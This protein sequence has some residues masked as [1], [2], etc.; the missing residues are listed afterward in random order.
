MSKQAKAELKQEVLNAID[1][2]V[3]AVGAGTT[4]KSDLKPALF[5]TIVPFNTNGVE[6]IVRKML[7][8]MSNFI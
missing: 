6:P 8:G 2:I 7:E 5:A 1:G 4:R 3:S